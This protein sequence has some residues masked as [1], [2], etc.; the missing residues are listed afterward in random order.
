VSEGVPLAT[1]PRR[2]H[3]EA[4]TREQVLAEIARELAQRRKFYPRWVAAV[5]LT[6]TH[7][8]ERIDALQAGYDY[9]GATWP[10]TQAKLPL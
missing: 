2:W 7:A 8:D 10:A 9:I 4:P 5:K 3:G 6:Q 1:E